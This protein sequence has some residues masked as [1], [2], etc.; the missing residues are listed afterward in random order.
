MEFLNGSK[1]AIPFD[2]IPI[3]AYECE[4]IRFLNFALSIREITD[5]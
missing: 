5:I 3:K 1:H 2:E 4:T